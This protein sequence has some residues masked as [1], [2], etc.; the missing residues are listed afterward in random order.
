MGVRRR[1]LS[2]RTLILGILLA[3]SDGRPGHL[4]RV[5]RA[6]DG[7]GAEDR[8]RLGVVAPWSHGPHPLSYRQVE[9][10][11][12]LLAAALAKERPDGAPGELLQRLVD[13]LAEASVPGRYKAASS[14]YAVDWTDHEAFARPV[15]RAECG[16]ADPE[17]SWGHRNAGGQAKDLFFGYFLSALTMVGDESGTPVPELAR[18]LLLS[19]CHV[20]PVPSLV[21]V[22]EHMVQDGVAVSD[23]ICD[24][25]YA[26]RVPGHWA[27]PLRR[28]GTGLV[29]DLHPHDRGPKGTFAGAVISNGNLYCPATP[30]ALLELGPLAKDA[31]V[32]QVA[33]HD[34]QS[35]ELARYK[36]RRM[37]ADDTDGYH[38]RM[39]P[40]VAGKVCC[41]LRPESMARGGDRPEILAVPEHP[42]SCCRQQTITV[43]PEVTA[44]TAQRH[45]YPSAAH[46]LSY[47]RRT[48]AERTNATVKDPA[49]TDI[50][51]GFCRVMG[52]S[53]ITVLVAC[54]LVVRNFRVTDAFEARQLEDRRR[55][56]AG[57]ARRTRRRRRRTIV[58]LVGAPNAPP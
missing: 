19:S 4:R 56:A 1:Q 5:H 47:A 48:A 31:G 37:G 33:A 20:D 34:E 32:E 57:L 16:G 53:A 7:L 43:P 36:L 13:A 44:K 55:Q 52:L 11:F 9:Y 45:D 24:S 50:S 35:A 40:A 6:L 23:V 27:L 38:R 39:C 26:H 22:I 12:S 29:M 49:S 18:R 3:V 58:D 42:P 8:A 28:L 41:P 15:G 30:T 25:G 10:T 17:A 21:P 2:V 54:A 51:R 46:R 14:S